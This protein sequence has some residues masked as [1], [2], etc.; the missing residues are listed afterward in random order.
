MDPESV[1]EEVFRWGSK[2]LTLRQIQQLA[3]DLDL[4]TAAARSELEVM[5]SGNLTDMFHDPKCVQVIVYIT[6]QGEK[7]SLRDM[8]ETFLVVP[9]VTN[10][11]SKTHAPSERSWSTE[12]TG[13]LS[14]ELAQIQILL[15]VP[16]ED[17]VAL[18]VELESSRA[19]VA[20][21]KT[22]LSK[23]NEKALELWLENCKQLI[24]FDSGILDRWRN[25]NTQGAVATEGTRAGRTEA[26]K[27][28][29]SR[30]QN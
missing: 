4:P 11:A 2:R 9:V 28:G 30:C 24:Q 12:E 16:E 6:D 29:R 14:G 13:D 8:S 22:E 26:I 25:A 3:S 18:N 15:Q 21:L 1:V 10:S 7:L 17:K 20:L 23:V 5:V 27:L 19:E